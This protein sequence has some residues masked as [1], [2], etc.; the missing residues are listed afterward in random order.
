MVWKRMHVLESRFERQSEIKQDYVNFMEQ[1]KLLGHMS[2]IQDIE[3]INA[4]NIYYLPHHSVIKSN[5]LTS[6]L[7]VVFD[8]SARSELG[9]SLNHKLLIGSVLQDMLF[10]LLLKFRLHQ[11]VI[12]GDLEMMY[13]QILVRDQDRDLQ[14]IL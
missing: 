13:G 11:Y 2:L 3:P 8:A 5:A 12:T 1:Y 10:E 9:T 6:K 14:R 4:G 7:I